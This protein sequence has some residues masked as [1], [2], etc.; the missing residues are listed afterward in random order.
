[1][2]KRSILF[3]LI[4]ILVFSISQYSSKRDNPPFIVVLGVAQDAGYPHIGCKKRCCEDVRMGKLSRRSVSCLAV[5]DPVSNERWLFDATP[6]ITTQLRLLDSLA[7][8]HSSASNPIGINGMFLTHAH[9]GHY[10]GLMYLGR[11]GMGAKNISVHAMPRMNDFLKTN[12]PWSQLVT[13]KNIELHP[14]AEDQSVALNERLT[15]TP[16]RV[17][18]RDEFSETVGFIITSLKKSA[19]FIPDI[20]K[21]ER[22][23][24]RIEEYLSKVDVAFLDGTF[25]D[26]RELPGR[27]MNE[28]PHPFI[29]E[30]MKR[31]SSLP[32]SEKSKIKFIHLNHTNPALDPSSDARK[33]VREAGFEIAEVGEKIVL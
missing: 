23:D 31:F 6:D 18:H 29:T 33:A 5:V 4:I 13:L 7:P 14:L 24:R 21:W 22:W 8:L 30:S 28:I 11:E 1:M 20:D 16:I 15:V 12:G 3:P 9:I 32:P 27:S 17:P 25:F 19:L 10:T 2:S 26:E